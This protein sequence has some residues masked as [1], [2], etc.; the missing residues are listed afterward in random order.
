MVHATVYRTFSQGLRQVTAAVAGV[1]LAW[2]V[3]NAFGLDTFSVAVVLTLG[4]AVGAFHWFGQEAITVA[5]TA[6]VVLTTGFSDDGSMSL[7]RL[8]DTAIGIIVGLL[9]N[10]VVWPPL[11]RRTAISAMNDIDDS[12]GNLLADMG[13]GLTDGWGE[14]DI[15]EWV[16]RT[17][18]LDGDLDH[19][20]AWSARHRKADG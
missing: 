20:W 14:D 9:V 8:S 19:A 11:R 1:L 2:S 15:L 3:G 10:A 16:D 7:D 6:L 17:R 4:L 18:T 5:A 13:A 12:I